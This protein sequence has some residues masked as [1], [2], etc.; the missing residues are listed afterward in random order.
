MLNSFLR[1]LIFPAILLPMLVTGCASHG[2]LSMTAK[3]ESEPLLAELMANTDQYLVYYHGNS[4]KIVSGI[5]FDPKKDTKSIQPEGVLWAEVSDS[6]TITDI[7][8]SIKRGN[9]PGYFPRLYRIFS[10]EGDFYG[11]L[12]T[13]WQHLVIQNVDE[14]TVRVYG[15]EGPPEYLDIGPGVSNRYMHVVAY[16]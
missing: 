1:Y 2:K 13:G 14:Q 6:K 3:A 5:L 7:I 11:Y 8:D 10:A 16:R 9:F 15:L 12:F 4:E